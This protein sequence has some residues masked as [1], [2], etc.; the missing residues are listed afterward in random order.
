MPVPAIIA[1]AAAELHGNTA[2]LEK[3]VAGIPPEQW[4]SRP[5]SHS[6]HLTWIVGH[7]LWARQA[8]LSR[9]G[10]EWPHPGLQVFARGVKID[11]HAVYPAPEALLA[12][13]RECSAVLASTLENITAEAL[14]APAPPGPPTPDGKVSGFI[15]VL[16]WHD[17]YHLGQI[18][19][20][21]CWLG[22]PG[23]F[24]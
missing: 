7:A 11:P 5:N 24:G 16:A 23:V 19:Y 13:W 8:L 20:L 10:T 1:A 9:I 18:A 6:N 21:R 12:G 14:A 22:Y 15:G 3:A 4:L 2:Y 17:T